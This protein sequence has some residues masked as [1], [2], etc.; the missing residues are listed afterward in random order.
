MSQTNT[1]E[2]RR[3]AL[4][5]TVVDIA[6]AGSPPAPPSKAIGEEDDPTARAF[7]VGPD[8]TVTPP[9]LPTNAPATSDDFLKATQKQADLLN[10]FYQDVISQST[11]S[12]T[13]ALITAGAGVIIFMA[14]LTFM[15][16]NSKDAA[17]MTTVAG[18]IIQVVA[19]LQFYLYAKTS[20][21]LSS[22]HVRLMR[23]QRFL[24][25]NNIA[26]SLSSPAR[27]TAI[28]TLVNTIASAEW[29]KDVPD[30]PLPKL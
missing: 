16:N 28:A 17:I 18:A 11:R 7:T 5:G 2:S 13:W 25:A 27:D 4:T 9:T 8:G 3:T 6:N 21:Q 24:L 12:F 22:F 14:A 1:D 23:L 15:L 26:N 20:A 10:I 29:D 30:V 19:G